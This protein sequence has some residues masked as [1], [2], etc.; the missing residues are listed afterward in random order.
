MEEVMAKTITSAA[1]TPLMSKVCR[2]HLHHPTAKTQ[3]LLQHIDS[4]DPHI[5]FT[6]EDSKQEGALP[7]LDTLV[8]SS[9]NNT[10]V[11]TVYR[12]PT[13]M[14][15]YLHW[16]SNQFISAKTSLFNTLV[17]GGKWYAPINIH[18]NKKFNT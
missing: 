9:P 15:Q 18:Y 12:K 13:H 5:Q 8:S 4:Q 2:Q 1:Y 16:N 14:E 6:T 10:L 11:T 3:Q 17:F 7:F